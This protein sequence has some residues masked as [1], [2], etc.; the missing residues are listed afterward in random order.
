[1]RFNLRLL[2][3]A[4]FVLFFL[5]AILGGLLWANLNFVRSVPGGGDFYVLWKGGQNFILSAA[6]PYQ[7]L[8]K[9]LQGLVFGAGARPAG[10]TLRRLSLPLY[11]L[12][13]FS[14]FIMIR[15]ALLARAAW[16]VFLEVELIGLVFLAVEL[17][18]WKPGRLYI[19]LLVLFGVFW[20]PAVVSLYSG[21]AIIF[22]AVLVIGALRALEFGADELAGALLALT[23]FNLE[24]VAPVVILILFW[25]L[26]SRRLR[27]WAGFLLATVILVGFSVFFSTTW[28]LAYLG[29]VLAN[30]N[31]NAAPTTYSLFTA[32]LPG[33]GLR[34]AQ[35]VTLAALLILIAE[36]RAVRGKDLRWLLWTASL[37]IA[38]TPLLGMPF[39]PA[40]LV[41]S[42]PGLLLVLAIME[43]RWG[44]FG[45]WSALA[46]FCVVFFGLWAAFRANVGSVFVVFYPLML[47]F[48]LYWVRWWAVRP[49]RLWADIISDM[50]K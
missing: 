18:H 8:T 7:D 6:A 11:V 1:M 48:L 17:L 14:P 28:L 37:T 43:Q 25:T 45:R 21:S 5:V 12:L 2:F 47:I 16:M 32:W 23:W 20:A 10:E 34:I 41:L 9:S 42:F 3:L 40:W 46:L 50:G 44:T 36:W 26:L 31:S 29:A 4:L 38:V 35:G 30:W 22:Q 19:T 15:D 49:P 27:V 13:V 39:I 33:I 24:A